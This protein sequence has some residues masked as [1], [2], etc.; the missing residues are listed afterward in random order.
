MFSF[1]DIDPLGQWDFD[2]SR[3]QLNKINEPIKKDI[4]INIVQRDY[5]DSLDVGI[6]NV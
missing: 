2:E 3:V 5:D 6:I 4:K 1:E